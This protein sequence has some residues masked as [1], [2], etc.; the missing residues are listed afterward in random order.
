MEGAIHI[1]FHAANSETI[2]DAKCSEAFELDSG[3][4][5]VRIKPNKSLKV[6]A[7]F[8]KTDEYGSAI[9]DPSLLQVAVAASLRGGR[10]IAT[11]TTAPAVRQRGSLQRLT[12]GRWRTVKT[13]TIPASS[14]KITGV[15]SG[16]YRVVI[17]PATD[18]LGATT[19]AVRVR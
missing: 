16:S 10:G 9:S 5:Q 3:E 19:S 1:C 13:F 4:V 12:S 17:S 7:F 2:D 14:W 8:P 15:P 11:G 6:Y 18:L